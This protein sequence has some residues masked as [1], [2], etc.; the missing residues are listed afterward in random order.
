[1]LPCSDVEKPSDWWDEDADKSLI[2]GIFKHGFGRYNSMRQD[3]CLSFLKRCGPPDDKALAAELKDEDDD[4]DDEDKDDSETEGT[5]D[6]LNG[7]NDDEDYVSLPSVNDLNARVRKL[8]SAYQKDFKRVQQKLQKS[9]RK[10]EKREKAEAE[11]KEREKLRLDAKQKWSKREENDFYRVISNYGLENSND[12][13]YIWDAFKSMSR[14]DKKYDDT[15]TDYA[16]AFLAMCKRVTNKEVEEESTIDPISEEKASKVLFRVSLLN[17]IRKDVLN[18]S[19]LDERLK[20]CSSSSELPTWYEPGIHDKYLLFA[21]A[22]HGLSKS[23]YYCMR[24]DE[25]SFKRLTNLSNETDVEDVENASWHNINDV[26]PKYKIVLNRLHDVCETVLTGEWPK[27][28]APQPSSRSSTPAS[29]QIDDQKEE[30]LRLSVHKR[31]T[32]ENAAQEEAAKQLQNWLLQSQMNSFSGLPG[33]D[34]KNS[35]YKLDFESLTGSESVSVVNRRSGKKLTSSKAPQLKNLAQWLRDH[36]SYD[37]DPAW[38][39]VLSLPEWRLPSELEKRRLPAADEL[40]TAAVSGAGNVMNPTSDLY[41]LAHLHLLAQQQ[42]LAYNP[43]FF[44]PLLAA[45]MNYASLMQQPD[46]AASTASPSPPQDLSVKKDDLP[47]DLS[48]K[49]KSSSKG[50]S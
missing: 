38:Y 11:S 3:S 14:L 23:A 24:D 43:L 12:G 6:V 13:G 8:V 34:L 41:G 4:E 48:V 44:N 28:S 5:A 50:K 21:A 42:A 45:S 29:S 1:M 19:Q 10:M 33:F 17:K 25:A 2:I 20:L 36:P 49:K 37:V 32:R 39:F 47:E 27:K 16:N 31:H 40:T 46:S 9:A 22:K 26:W 18:H 30:N 15:L 7:P 35:N